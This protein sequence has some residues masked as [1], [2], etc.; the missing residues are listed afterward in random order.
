MSNARV[1][2]PRAV[3]E[4]KNI[5]GQIGPSDADNWWA[6]IPLKRGR[7]REARAPAYPLTCARVK[8]EGAMG[9]RI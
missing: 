3:P 4:R 7:S 9:R 8:F 5:K 1:S 6:S 2:G